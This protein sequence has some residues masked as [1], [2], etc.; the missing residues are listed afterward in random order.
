MLGGHAGEEPAEFGV[1]FY[2]GL[3]EEGG[4]GGGEETAAYQGFGHCDGV[5]S[6][7]VGVGDLGMLEVECFS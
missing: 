1:L 7:V 4:L 5:V 2:W 3:D 6:D